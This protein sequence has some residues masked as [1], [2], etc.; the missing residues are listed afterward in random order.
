M[1]IIELACFPKLDLVTY[2]I[3]TYTEPPIRCLV[4]S[5]HSHGYPWL[6]FSECLQYLG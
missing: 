2:T 1:Y 3:Y 5:L 4:D 6:P